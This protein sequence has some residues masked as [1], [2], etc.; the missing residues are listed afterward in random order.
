VKKSPGDQLTAVADPG[1]VEQRLGVGDHVG[2]VVQHP[3]RL[4]IGLQDRGEQG[5]V[6]AAD[7]DNGAAAAEVVGDH[8]GGDPSSRQLGHGGVE[9]LPGVVV[10]AVAHRRQREAPAVEL[11]EDA[12]VG[13]RPQQPVQGGRVRAQRRSE[14][15][16]LPGSRRQLV[17]DAQLGRDADRLGQERAACELVEPRRG[18]GVHQRC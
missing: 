11:L 10:V 2:Q 9:G 3:S 8:G 5:A 13:E 15:L 6:A 4:R 18:G 17:G 14:L 1:V 16:D 12:G 7:V